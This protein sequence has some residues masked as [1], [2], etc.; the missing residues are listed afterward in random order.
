MRL[1]DV[2]ASPNCRKVRVTARE[3]GL[4]LE[5]VPVDFAN[6]KTPEYL[7]RNPTGKVPTL[8]DDDGTVV[9]ESGAILVHLAEKDPARSLFPAEAHARAETL[10]WMFFGATHIQPWMS[11]L[12]QERILKARAGGSPDPAI[13][14]LT[15]RELARFL[16]VLDGHL[17]G[18]EYLGSA[19]GIADIALG[20][21]FEGAEAR[22]VSLDAFTNLHAWRERLRARRSWKD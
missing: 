18:R 21:G 7:A 20:C 19:F 5:I 2:Q 11:V 22:G 9:W 1:Y 14:G 17:A 8:V 16:A 6:A 13:V 10:R 15:E 12:G 3:L 4:P